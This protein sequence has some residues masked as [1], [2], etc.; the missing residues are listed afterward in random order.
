M[1]LERILSE[2]SEELGVELSSEQIKLFLRYLE[3]LKIWNEKMNLTGTSGGKEVVVNHF[4]DSLSAALLISPDSTLL[5]I[6]SGA[7]FP[8]IP[9]KIAFPSIDVTLL[10]SVRKKIIFL[11]DVIRKL[12]L[13]GTVP[14]WGRAEDHENGVPRRR[15][16]FVISRAVGE[17]GYLLHIGSPYLREN[18]RIVLMRGKRGLD[19]WAELDEK[20]SSRF[21]LVVSK[22][23]TLPF[24]GSRR[25]ILSVSSVS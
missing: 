13:E 11:R 14:L 1:E 4:L 24:A 15:F 22:E 3:I 2:G 16:D 10:D 25:V 9:L 19:E 6:G 18:G 21:S 8:G 12:G 23:L 7:G 17:I 20:V 5:D